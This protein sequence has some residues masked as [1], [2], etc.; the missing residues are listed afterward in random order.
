M[1]TKSFL[2]LLSLFLIGAAVLLSGFSFLI[3]P[4]L[5]LSGIEN[6]K[7]YAHH[8]VIQLEGGYGITHL[9]LNGKKIGSNYKVEENGSYVLKGKSSLLWKKKEVSYTF[10][11]DTKPPAIPNIKERLKNIY[12]KE[13]VFTLEQEEN[14]TYHAA[15]NGKEI[16]LDQPIQEPGDNKLTITATKPNGLAAT[17]EISFSIDDRTFP[18]KSIR[19]FLDYYFSNDVHVIKKFTG[20]VAIHLN[21]DYNEEDVKMVEKAIAELKSFF[22]YKMEIQEKGYNPEFERTINMVFTPTNKFKDYSIDRND[23]WGAE[24]TPLFD[25][26]VGT[27]QSFVLIGT[28]PV[29]PREYRNTVILHELLHSIGLSNHIQSRNSPL[30]EYANTTVALGDLEKMYGEL[31]YLGDLEPTTQKDE[32]T[33]QLEQRIQ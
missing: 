21:G 5:K 33:K 32:A 20:N 1:R 12:F 24:M 18:E 22:P 9:T 26:V 19:Q 30:Y 15:L 13:A 10:E 4:T 8:P 16:S 3:E 11:V 14:V 28:D 31:L 6:G 7:V 23:V 2:I 17:K 25:P 29:I 27:K